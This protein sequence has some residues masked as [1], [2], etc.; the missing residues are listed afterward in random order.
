MK[1]LKESNK[2]IEAKF[3]TYR[4]EVEGVYIIECYIFIVMH[5]LMSKYHVVEK[6]RLEDQQR[7]RLFKEVLKVCKFLSNDAL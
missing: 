7:L 2:R 4:Q 5:L 6:E 1:V 3:E